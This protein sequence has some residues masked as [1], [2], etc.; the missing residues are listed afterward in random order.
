MRVL[1]VYKDYHPVVG[2]IEHHIQVLAEGLKE[3]GVDVH[4]LVTNTNR[5]TLKGEINGVP[6]T[7][8]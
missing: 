5:K 4:V 6:V 2:G 1:H 7:K 8:V 3:Q